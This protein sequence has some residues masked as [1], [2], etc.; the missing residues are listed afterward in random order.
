VLELRK[1]VAVAEI[2]SVHVATYGEAVR[3][4]ATEVEK[5][6]PQTR[7][8]ADHSIPYLVAAAL[9][10]G[11]VTPAT[12]APA[13]IQDAALRPLIK[14]LTVVEEPEFTRRYPAESCTRI[15]VTTTDGRLVAA[16]TRHPKG[17][18]GNPLTDAEVEEKF[19]GLAAGALE[20]KGCDRVL[21]E[22]W[23]LENAATL[24]GLFESMER[25]AP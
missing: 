19:R 6:N 15:E 7:E 5:W 25:R 4:T 20:A 23:T 13:R 1:Q 12:F 11:G 22:T 10:D 24:D 16:E 17:H 9:Q 2:A 3:R 14:K 18:S 8:T 21:A